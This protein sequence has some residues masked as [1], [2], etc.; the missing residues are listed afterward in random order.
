LCCHKYSHNLS[1]PAGSAI[2]WDGHFNTQ[3]EGE[4]FATVIDLVLNCA[5]FIYI[6]AWL[7]FGSYNVPELGIDVW[8]LVV[9]FIGILALRRIPALLLIYK[10]VPEIKSW[11]E[12]LFSGHFGE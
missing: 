9:L 3:V 1:D 11:R 7:P 6:G 5:G 10:A 4:V 8:K 2:S 12:A